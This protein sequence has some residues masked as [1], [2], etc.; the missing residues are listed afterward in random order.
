MRIVAIIEARMG[1]SRL[2]GKVL[3]EVL[4]HPILKFLVERLRRIPLLDD[5]VIATTVHSADDLICEFAKSKGI[6]FF[7]GSEEDVLDRVLCAA[8]YFNT[9]LIVEF[10][11]DCPLLDPKESQKVIEFFLNNSNQYDYVSNILTRTYP[12]GLDTQIFPVSVLEEVSKKTN[13]PIDRENVSL[14]IYEHPKEYRCGNVEAPYEITWPEL[15][16]TLDTIEDFKLIKTIFERLYP[17]NPLFST[18]NIITLLCQD[19]KLLMLN[20]HVQQK[21]IRREKILND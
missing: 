8:K 9:D 16:L 11:G 15:R 4:G 13:D 1:S 17:I 10:T 21:E 19:E 7:R 6:S 20:K 2:P 3:M 14:Y 12:R 18:I 5:V